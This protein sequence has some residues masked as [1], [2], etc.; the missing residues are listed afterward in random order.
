MATEDPDALIRALHKITAAA[1][2]AA[3]YASA[4]DRRTMDPVK[5]VLTGSTSR[6]VTELFSTHPLIEKR[7]AA[8][9]HI[10]VEMVS[11]GYSNAV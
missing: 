9:E 6:A 3:A 5:A 7:I 10:K 8:L 4:A 2:A 11:A 1:D